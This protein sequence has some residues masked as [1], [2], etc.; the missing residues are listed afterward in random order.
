M[1]Y[2]FGLSTSL[3]TQNWDTIYT[4]VYICVHVTLMANLKKFIHVFLCNGFVWHMQVWLDIALFSFCFGI[5][6]S[7]CFSE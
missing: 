5:C 6:S 1:C 7:E 4:P 3:A 2:D